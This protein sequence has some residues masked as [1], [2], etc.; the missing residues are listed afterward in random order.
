MAINTEI[1]CPTESGS[2]RSQGSNAVTKVNKSIF[3]HSERALFEDKKAKGSLFLIVQ[4]AFPCADCHEYF[5]KETQD[6]KKSIIFKIVG[7]NGCYSAE[8]GLGLETT[9]PKFIYYHLGN[10]LMVDKP[11][12]PPKFPKHLGITSIS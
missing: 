10:S 12:A 9:T 3:S 6:G 1:Y 2:W 8:H 5:K 11:A 7:N 4:D